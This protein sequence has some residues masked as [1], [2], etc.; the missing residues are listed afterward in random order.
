MEQVHALKGDAAEAVAGLRQQPGKD[1]AVLGSGELIRS[2][3]RRN[4]IDQFMLSI[5]PLILGSGA[6]C[7]PT[8]VRSPLSG[9][10][11]PRR[12]RPVW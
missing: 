2:L 1:L 8:V 5:H 7:S 3:M 11:P 9:S 10:S 6:V 12:R 4:L